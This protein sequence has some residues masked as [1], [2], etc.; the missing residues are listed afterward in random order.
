MG[1]IVLNRPKTD[2]F[3]L[4]DTLLLP[5]VADLMDPERQISH[6]DP[7]TFGEYS[8]HY[9]YS[10]SSIEFYL[11]NHHRKPLNISGSLWESMDQECWSGFVYATITLIIN[12]LVIG[13]LFTDDVEISEV[14]VRM[15]IGW[16]EPHS[17]TWYASI[18]SARI[19][20]CL[21]LLL[22]ISFNMFYNV[23]FRSSL[24]TQQF[25]IDI[26]TFEQID[27]LRDGFYVERNYLCRFL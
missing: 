15:S 19:C 17:I 5:D 8:M 26:D 1:S 23:E 14:F 2:T 3:H 10:L 25:P 12:V 21:W 9:I 4:H 6:W 7:P 16:L 13:H 22:G 27:I 24:I 11:I 18:K 20:I